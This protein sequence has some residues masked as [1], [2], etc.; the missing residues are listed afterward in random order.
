MAVE[1]HIKDR[2]RPAADCFRASFPCESASKQR[3]M[4]RFLA[5]F[6]A[7]AVLGACA[8]APSPARADT[9]IAQH[10]MIVAAERDA[11]EAGLEMLR[12][13]GSAVDAAIAAQLVLTLVEPQSSGIGGSAYIMVSDGDELYAYD[14]RETAPAS[15]TP[16]MYLDEEGN[17]LGYGEIRFGGISVGVPGTIAVMAMAHRAHGRLPWAR[18]FDPAIRLAEE[19]FAVPERLAAG[20]SGGRGRARFAGLPDMLNYFYHEDGTAYQAG[21]ILRNSELAD[22]YR[23]LAARGEEVFYHGALAEEIA[24]AVTHAPL[25]PVPFTMEDLENYRAIER[26]AAP[27]AAIAPAVFRLPLRAGQP[28]CRFWGCSN[29]FLPSN[30]KD[31]RSLRRTLFPRQAGLPMPIARAGLA[32]PILSIFRSKGFWIPPIWTAAHH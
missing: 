3:Q 16:D 22:T 32:I 23:L 9:P 6:T 26:V 20:L 5:F 25:N 29:I 11:S 28:C 31:R 7:L 14:G 30:C 18:L 12:A 1:T 10:H 19:G 17:T 24:D 2:P 15:A 8:P 13:G 21:E 27:I 4:K